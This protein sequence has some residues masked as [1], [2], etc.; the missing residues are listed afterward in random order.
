M[1]YGVN[2]FSFVTVRI[3]L[4]MLFFPVV[5]FGQKITRE[6]YIEKYKDIAIREMEKTGIPASITLAQGCLESGNGNSELAKKA[7]NHFGI[8]CHSTWKGKGFYMDDDAKDECFRVYKDPEESYRDHSD[9]LI[10]GRRYAFLFELSTTDYKGWAKGLKKAGYATNPKYP[11]LLINI[12]EE[13]KLYEFDSKKTRK[14]RTTENEAIVIN[15]ESGT[16]QLSTNKLPR[17]YPYYDSDEIK[18]HENFIKYYVPSTEESLQDIANKFEMRVWQ[19]IKYN[20]LPKGNK[21]AQANQTLFLQPKRWKA[22]EK[23]HIV[24]PGE[25]VYEISQTYGIKTKWIYK[26]NNLQKDSPITPGMKLKLR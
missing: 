20:E 23:F 5:L 2:P 12:I 7:N 3:F 24:K 18:F 14:N 21:V 1:L 9:F 8:K 19:I 13:N 11:E 17:L 15:G 10:N 25:T 22:Q 6:Q 4:L 26:R 16:N